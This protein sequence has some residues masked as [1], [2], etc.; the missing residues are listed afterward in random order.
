MHIIRSPYGFQVCESFLI[1]HPVRK[2]RAT[3]TIL[4]R[5]ITIMAVIE[6]IDFYEQTHAA[7]SHANFVYLYKKMLN[8]S[9]SNS[10]E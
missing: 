4:D 6:R 1:Y 7:S 8:R 2:V 10:P 3:R 9:Y 5:R